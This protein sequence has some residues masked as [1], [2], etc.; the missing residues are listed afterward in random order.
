VP[1]NALLAAGLM[2]FVAGDLI[3]SA[4]AAL[5]F[6]AAWKLAGGSDQK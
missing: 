6:P 1:G 2:P 3:K 5:A 4:L